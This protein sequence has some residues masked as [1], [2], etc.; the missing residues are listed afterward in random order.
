MNDKQNAG[1]LFIL[2][3]LMIYFVFFLIPIIF[4]IKFS[5]MEYDGIRQAVFVGLKKYYAV[6][7][8]P[9]FY[10]VVL[11][12]LAYVAVSVPLIY[13]TTLFLAVLV[14]NTILG[15][16]IFKGI[17]Y[18]PSMVSAIVVGLVWKWLLGDVGYINSL[19]EA[20]GIGSLDW[21]INSDLSRI[22]LVTG[23]IWARSGFFMIIFLAGLENVPVNLI[24]AATIDGAGSFQ[25]FMKIT[26]PYLKPTS[27]LILLL[28][29][30]TLF[31]EYGLILSLTGGGPGNDTTLLVQYLFDK[32]FSAYDYGY[33]SVVSIVLLVII[34]IITLINFQISKEGQD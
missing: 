2:P 31:K 7:S 24:E 21:F 30:I 11:Q 27:F 19:L 20:L 5:F 8:D 6:F 26:L 16:S 18:W 1:Y 32:G 14:K 10:K 17:F 34:M 28:S 25:T 23:T 9:L 4:T 3:N 22:V 13:L 29:M 33:A 15:K 12:T